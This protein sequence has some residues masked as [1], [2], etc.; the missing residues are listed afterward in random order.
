[1]LPA[2]QQFVGI[3]LMADIPDDFIL[4][5]IEDIMQGDGQ[6]HGTQARCEVPSGSGDHIDDAASDLCG[7]PRELLSGQYF[8]I[9][10]GLNGFEQTH[11]N[12]LCD[13][14]CS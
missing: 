1:M 5:N 10:R 13:S 11:V 8:E 4:G 12:F 7:K 2:S 3:G 6:F 9:F 14:A